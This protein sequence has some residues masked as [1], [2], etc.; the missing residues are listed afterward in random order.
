LH[1]Y[2][3]GTASWFLAYGIQTVMFAWLVTMVLRESPER[4]GL[5]QMSLLLPGTLLILVGGSY[6]DR[7]GG[8]QVLVVAQLFAVLASVYLLIIVGS[9]RLSFSLI[10]GYAMLMGL[11]QAFVTPSRDG[12]LSL[13]AEGRLQRTVMITSIIQFGMQ[14]FGFLIAS[15]SDF[16]GPGLIIGV[17]AGV[18]LLGVLAFSRI[19]GGR[20]SKTERAS[21]LVQSVVEGAKTVF[22][23]PSMRV[24]MVQNIAMAM[25]FMGSYIV[26]MPLIVREVYSGTAQDLAFMNGAN[27]LGLVMTIV[28]L[29]RLGDV[30]RQGRA[31]L[32]AQ[33]LGAIVLA[34]AGLA[35]SYSIWVL[36]LF[37]WGACGGIAMTM[38]R[39][40]MQEQAPEAQRGRVMSFYSFSF[41][42]AGP[43]GAVLCGYL[44][45]LFGPQA[46]LMMSAGA[47]L[48]VMIVVTLGSSLWQLQGHTHSSI[49]P[50][51][52]EDSEENRRVV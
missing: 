41:M 46:A 13:V 37:V 2:L 36:A 51:P 24:V 47:M 9:D 34:L 22:S 35:P 16:T 32:L 23:S 30:R 11:A 20:P 38:S 26:T 52:G 40:I 33:G 19:K 48:M 10:I 45:E 39:T 14:M 15:L 42:G 44:V 29:L 50:A 5:A 7:F 28:L 43:V 31:L 1:Y 25:F 8:R 18:L 6:S 27:S 49:Q 4:V 21:K 17:Q 12:L 3:V